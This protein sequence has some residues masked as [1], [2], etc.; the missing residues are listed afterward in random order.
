MSQWYNVERMKYEVWTSKRDPSKP[1]TLKVTYYLDKGVDPVDEWVC[2]GH[3]GFAREKFESWWKE[4]T[5]APLPVDAEEA[6]EMTDQLI[7]P[8]AIQYEMQGKYPRITRCSFRATVEEP[9][10]GR[11]EEAQ[12]T[13][14]GPGDPGEELPF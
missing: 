11:K 8:K 2:P 10:K 9:A 7:Q 1:K 14:D 5:S 12:G 4:R 3:Q 6:Y 13:A